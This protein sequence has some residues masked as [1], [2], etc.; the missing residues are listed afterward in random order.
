[1]R[2]L[3]L[4]VLWLFQ[5]LL[6]VAMVGSG[7]EKFR[8]PAWERMFQRWGYPDHFY[9][10]VGA[11]EVVAGLALLVPRTASAGAIVLVPVMVAAAITQITQG[12]RSGVGELVFA[13]LLAA[14]AWGRWPG[15]L[16]GLLARLRVGGVRRSV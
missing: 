16:E 10:V 14:I 11:V 1:M 2:H 8:S 3:K 6:A 12:G 7:V 15:I 13:A 9:L 5:I 4:I